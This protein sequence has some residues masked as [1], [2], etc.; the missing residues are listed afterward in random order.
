M[1]PNEIVQPPKSQKIQRGGA[2]GD[3][4]FCRPHPSP[5]PTARDAMTLL[6]RVKKNEPNDDV[7]IAQDGPYFTEAQL[8]IK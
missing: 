5:S 6:S 4:C 8:H 2:R 3:V 1:A 7:F